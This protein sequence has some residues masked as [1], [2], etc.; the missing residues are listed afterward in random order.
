MTKPNKCPKCKSIMRKDKI[1]ETFRYIDGYFCKRCLLF[2]DKNWKV[3]DVGKVLK[4]ATT[5]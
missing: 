1:I 4:E 3:T 2:Y 5:K